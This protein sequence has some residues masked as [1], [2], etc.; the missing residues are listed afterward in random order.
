MNRLDPKTPAVAHVTTWSPSTTK[1]KAPSSNTHR[2]LAAP[3]PPG[4]IAA[5]WLAALSWARSVILPRAIL[6]DSVRTFLERAQRDQQEVQC[7]GGRT[8]GWSSHDKRTGR[9]A[10]SHVNFRS[11]PRKGDRATGAYVYARN[12]LDGHLATYAKSAGASQISWGHEEDRNF[13]C[14][15]QTAVVRKTLLTAPFVM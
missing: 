13:K 5:S 14:L 10:C 6:A 11:T 15:K 12:P 1:H 9:W 8:G 3:K 4:K 7:A 2:F